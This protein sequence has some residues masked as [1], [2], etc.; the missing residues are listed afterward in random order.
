MDS[1][2]DDQANRRRLSELSG[3][4]VRI[5]GP[6]RVSI[7]EDIQLD[8]ISAGAVLINAMIT[9]ANTWIG[10]GAQVGTSGLARIQ[11]AKIGSDVVLGAGTY[12]NCVLLRRA[13]ARGFAE[14]RQGTVLEEEAEVGHNVGLKNTVF[15]SGV[16]AGSLINFCD[17]LL[18]GGS[19]RS[20]HSEVG[21]GAVHFNFDPRGDKFGSIMGDVTGC[22]LKSRRI[23]VGG[24]SGIVAPVHL[25]F[26]AVVAAGSIVRKDVAEN[27]LSSGDA[28]GQSGDYD[29]DRYFDLSRK[30]IT[31][32]KLVG[33]LHALRAWYE[34]VRLPCCDSG[35][36]PLYIAAAEEFDSHIRH[37][38][39]ELGK[40]IAK[41]EK[42]LAM[43]QEK[44]EHRRFCDQHRALLA[45]AD[46]INSSLLQI[47]YAEPPMKFISEY[48]SLRKN[49][50]HTYAV[51]E[52][53]TE[54]S[55]LAAD[56]LRQI[57][58]RAQLEM[59][60]V[61]ETRI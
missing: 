4:G 35:D 21:S 26:G 16:V 10:A 50:T 15:T 39:K 8:R 32:A 34:N 6:E 18:T 19:S 55:L 9:G 22:L 43:S 25:G 48:E 58:S 49:R 27:Q 45:N 3:R 53:S 51:R 5:S 23:F 20:D 29:L 37:R 14:L 17:V 36:K 47:N 38:A 54:A 57:A 59:Q 46:R 44:A 7:G 60:A 24:N 52:L 31:A 30:F 1:I 33:N 41:L 13:K 56:W 12:E 61:F 40:V 2:Y 28:P 42:S 11:D